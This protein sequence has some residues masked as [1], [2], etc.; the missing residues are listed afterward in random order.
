MMSTIHLS[1]PVSGA[2]GSPKHQH[3]VFVSYKS[4]E[5][6]WMLPVLGGGSETPL[7]RPDGILSALKC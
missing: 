4:S 1:G 2:C 3:I 7:G 6:L 5:R